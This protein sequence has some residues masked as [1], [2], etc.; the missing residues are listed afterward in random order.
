MLQTSFI[1]MAT[2]LF[3]INLIYNI[4][5]IAKSEGGRVSVAP[6]ISVILG[7]GLVFWGALALIL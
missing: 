7:I 4:A 6:F 1:L 5:L 3:I 2:I